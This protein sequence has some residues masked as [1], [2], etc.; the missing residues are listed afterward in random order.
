MRRK[1]LRGEANAIFLRSRTI[2]HARLTHSDRTDAS[3]DLALRQVAV[4]HNTLTAVLGEPVSVLGDEG[5]NFHL[6]RL[7]QRG[8]GAVAKNFC[9]R[10]GER[11]WR[12]ELGNVSRVRR[13]APLVEKRRHESL[14]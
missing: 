14:P 4:S 2:A 11:P 8:T 12:D 9:Q 6:H 5:C 7:C 10:V 13:I 1:N 3:H